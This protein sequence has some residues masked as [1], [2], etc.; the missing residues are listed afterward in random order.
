MQIA[1]QFKAHFVVEAAVVRRAC[2]RADYIVE[3]SRTLIQ[4]L[5]TAVY[6]GGLYAEA[7]SVKEMVI[8]LFIVVI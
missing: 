7:L 8:L 5:N 3:R 2:G 6:D 1:D 4:K